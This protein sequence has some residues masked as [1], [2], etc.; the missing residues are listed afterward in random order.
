MDVAAILDP[1]LFAPVSTSKL[2][3]VQKMV[4]YSM[5]NMT[6]LTLENAGLTMTEA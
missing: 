6:N 3:L 1:V 5:E 4:D 2:S